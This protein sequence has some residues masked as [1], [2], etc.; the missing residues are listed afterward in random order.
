[1]DQSTDEPV[2][3][4]VH[5]S[6]TSIQYSSSKSCSQKHREGQNE[7]ESIMAYR[8]EITQHKKRPRYTH[9]RKWHH[10]PMRDFA[11]FVP[12]RSGRVAPLQH[13]PWG[14]GFHN[15]NKAWPKSVLCV[16]TV[17]VVSFVC[18]HIKNTAKNSKICST[19]LTR[20]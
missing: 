9:Q 10:Y 17:P 1:M 11:L 15:N 18:I 19:L 2:K 3:V 12:V 20:E 14:K 4:G 5:I 13:Q 8:G 6:P 16:F 7:T